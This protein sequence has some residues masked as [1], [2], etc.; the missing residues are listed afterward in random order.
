MLKFSSEFADCTVEPLKSHTSVF[1][2][3][4]SISPPLAE[5]H[6]TLP[7]VSAVTCCVGLPF[8]V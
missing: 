3:L 4:A 1:A 6:R 5:S 7:S 8:A 2:R